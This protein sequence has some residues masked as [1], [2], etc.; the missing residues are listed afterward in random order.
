MLDCKILL[1][2]LKSVLCSILF[3]NIYLSNV[4]CRFMTVMI[5]LISGELVD[6]FWKLSFLEFA[7]F[8]VCLK[9]GELIWEEI[10]A[11]FIPWRNYF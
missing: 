4:K 3:L 8:L 1:P 2:I 10:L 7:D 9:V 5:F 6:R 11:R